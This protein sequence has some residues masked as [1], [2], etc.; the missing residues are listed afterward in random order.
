MNINDMTVKDFRKLPCVSWEED[1]GVYDCLVVVPGYKKDMHDSGYRCMS[2]V[3][4]KDEKPLGIISGCSDVI[5]FDGIGGY[6]KD[7]ILR[8]G[9]PSM[10]SVSG[11]NIDCLPTSGL[12]RI[13]TSTHKMS[14]DAPLS[15]F[16]IYKEDK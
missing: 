12:L 2:F 4:V 8:G 11:W 5:H 15:S 3:P 9:V 7:W 1:L 14:S 10:V 6:G 16:E 13:F